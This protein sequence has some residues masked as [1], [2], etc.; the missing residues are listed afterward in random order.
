MN[1][2]GLKRFFWIFCAMLV[3]PGWAG[4]CLK[5]KVSPRVSLS[6]PE[7][8]MQIVQP[9][10]QMNF[11]HGNVLATLV[12]NYELI[13]DVEQVDGGYC[14]FLKKVKAQVG[15]KDFLVHIDSRHAPQTCGYDAILDHEKKH[16][17]AYLSLVDDMK[18][19]VKEGVEDAAD[20]VMPVFVEK[21]T[22]VPS[23][24]DGM[25]LDLRT[26]PN[27]ILVKQKLRAAQEIRNNQIDIKENGADFS[28]CTK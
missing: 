8:K 11:W 20:S 6:V 18:E 19:D 26:H 7:W 4:N 1:C 21:I 2:G 3:L 16:V 14:V 12:D 9:K 28:E 27:L 23:V 22:D 24:I 25:N 5:Y 10:E 15:Y 17:L 13:T